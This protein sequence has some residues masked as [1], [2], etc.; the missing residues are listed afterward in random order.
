MLGRTLRFI[1]IVSTILLSILP[2]MSGNIRALR[3]I[4]ITST[5]LTM[6]MSFAHTLELTGKMTYDG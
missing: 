1:P 5:A 6:G 3:F 4:A 2:T